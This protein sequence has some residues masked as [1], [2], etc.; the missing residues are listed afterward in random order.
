MNCVRGGRRSTAVPLSSVIS[1]GNPAPAVER[2]FRTLY[3]REL[4]YSVYMC[5]Y[6]LFVISLVYVAHC[7][8][9][10]YLITVYFDAAKSCSRSVVCV[11]VSRVNSRIVPVCCTI[12]TCVHNYVNIVTVDYLLSCLGK[13]VKIYSYS[14]FQYYQLF[15]Y[16]RIKDYHQSR[17]SNLQVNVVCGLYLLCNL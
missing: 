14:S 9:L 7:I 12:L 10:W 17:F 16:W 15:R 6:T 8:S 2:H 1:R 11:R 4:T 13:L 3:F 5:V